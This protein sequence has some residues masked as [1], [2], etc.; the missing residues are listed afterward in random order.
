MKRVYI[1]L[2]IC[3]LSVL[4][5]CS[6][7]GFVGKSPK[8]T[9]RTSEEKM[10]IKNKRVLG[11]LFIR[12]RHLLAYRGLS[13]RG[14]VAI[15]H[16]FSKSLTHA[17]L[18]YQINDSTL[19]TEI[20]VK[21][22]KQWDTVLHHRSESSFSEFMPFDGVIE[23]EDFNGDQI[24]DLMVIAYYWDI[25]PGNSGNLWLFKNGRFEFVEGFLE[26]ASPQYDP[27][28]DRIY[29]YQSDGCA[30]MYMLFGAYKIENNKTVEEDFVD[31]DCCLYDEGVCI[32]TRKDKSDTVNVSETYKYIPYYFQEFVKEKLKAVR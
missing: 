7:H 16:L 12:H 1:T 9:I 13:E 4:V 21:N 8:V 29:S 2:L 17:V 6:R 30:D 32:I 5:S 31:C 22:G 26:I 14:E 15:G 18:A 28:S 11:K 20:L 24:P 25:H 27:E 19:L 3:I 10:F 23:T